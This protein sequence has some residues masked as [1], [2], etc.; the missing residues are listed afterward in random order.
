M[1]KEWEHFES[2][3]KHKKD[4][5]EIVVSF[6]PACTAEQVKL[7]EHQIK[8]NLPNDF[9]ESLL[10]HNG[11][12]GNKHDYCWFEVGGHQWYLLNTT[13]MF[14]Y[15]DDYNYGRYDYKGPFSL[16]DSGVKDLEWDRK[17]LPV[18]ENKNGMFC[19]IDMNPG[20]GGRTGQVFKLGDGD[21]DY[22][23]VIAKSFK[24]FFDVG[25]KK[26]LETV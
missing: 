3:I 18:A 2:L 9:K 10:V 16:K 15:W 4:Y 12:T 23:E 20:S 17:W 13:D 7:F 25:S 6:N 21:G 8:F 11:F 19:C 26:F 1:K 5:M 14:Y 22:H 24:E